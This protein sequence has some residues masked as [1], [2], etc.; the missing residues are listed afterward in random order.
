MDNQEYLEIHI[1]NNSMVRLA[2]LS[3][4]MNAMADEFREFCEENERNCG[5]E[6]MVKEIRRGSIDILLVS[7]VAALVPLAENLNTI[8]EFGKHIC[9]VF[10]SLFTKS[11]ERDSISLRTL[12]NVKKI[13][14]PT[15][16]DS[17]GRTEITVN[18]NGNTVKIYD[19][20]NAEAMRITDSAQYVEDMERMPEKNIFVKEL[21]YF[22]QVRDGRGNVGDRAVIDRF[23]KTPK[24]VVYVDPDFKKSVIES[25]RNIF[26]YGFLVDVEVSTVA[27]KVAA[28]KVL[29]F[30]ERF[31]L[32]E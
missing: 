1:R 30:H 8:A 7:S 21:L 6:L 11:P 5:A 29:K 12:E 23:S 31:L 16:K 3:E 4:S 18:G 17:G 19:F 25:E 20:G 13:V 2:D 9:Q 27:G 32:E 26:D 14:S 15:A 10:T 24:K 28:Y 22:S